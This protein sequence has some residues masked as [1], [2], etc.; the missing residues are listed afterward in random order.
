MT[1]DIA[2]GAFISVSSASVLAAEASQAELL[3][4]AKI[5]EQQAQKTALT[6]V[7]HGVVKSS[8]LEREHGK[9]IWSVDIAAPNSAKTMDVQVD[10]MTGKFLS[11]KSEALS[12]K[13]ME[14]KTHK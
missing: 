8:E 13:V 2:T 6:E 1:A 4:Q 14:T 10:A 11:K 3:K 5:T 9:L 12:K 7:P